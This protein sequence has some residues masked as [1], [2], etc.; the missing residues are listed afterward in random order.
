M[1]E[2]LSLNP[3]VF[4]L[5]INDGSLKIIKLKKKRGIFDLV[6]YNETKIKP[7]IIKNGVI[8]DE[9]GLTEAIKLVCATVKGKKLNTKYVVASLPE[10]KS[11]LQV[12]QMPKMAESELLNALPF[13]AENYIPLPIDQVYLGFKAITPAEDHSEQLDVLIAA[14]PK[15]IVDSYNTCLKKAGLV[16]FGLEVESEA[17]ARAL[18]KSET[19]T[20]PAIILDIEENKVGFIVFSGHSI[21]FTC[22][23]PINLSRLRVSGSDPALNDLVLQLKKYIG[24]YQDNISREPLS[25]DKS[26]LKIIL[27]GQANNL[28]GLAEILLKELNMPVELGNPWIN[29][30]P[31]GSDKDFLNFYKEPLSFSAAIGL[32]LRAADNKM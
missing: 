26:A 4:G 30:F 6:S 11:F 19:N 21:R 10:E 16:P 2:F 24:F 20:P 3:E 27:C 8:Q 22:S 15:K 25:E 12:I 7:G 1:L 13:E 17:I 29:V 9:A 14:M 32:A 23:F 31:D 5:D 28:K 18:I